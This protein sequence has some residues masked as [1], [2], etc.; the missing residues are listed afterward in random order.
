MSTAE[1]R[2]FVMDQHQLYGVLAGRVVDMRQALDGGTDLADVLA[3]ETRMVLDSPMTREQIASALVSVLARVAQG[4][5]LHADH[6]ERL[7]AAMAGVGALDWFAEF[8]L[9]IRR[10]GIRWPIPEPDQP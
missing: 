6:D 3:D 7:A 4:E 1:Q 8:V 9:P 5:D 2:Q 10:G